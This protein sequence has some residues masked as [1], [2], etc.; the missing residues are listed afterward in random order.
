MKCGRGVSTGGLGGA[1]GDGFQH[2]AAVFPVQ[3]V[4]A[5]AGSAAV[6]DGVGQFAVEDARDLGDAVGAFLEVG[7]DLGA[8]VLEEDAL[9]VEPGLEEGREAQLSTLRDDDANGLA[10][11]LAGFDVLEDGLLVLVQ[12]E[13][14]QLPAAV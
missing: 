3:P 12:L 10:C 1:L 8:D 9:V 2:G 14:D 4:A 7:N 6:G 5:D 13:G 11:A